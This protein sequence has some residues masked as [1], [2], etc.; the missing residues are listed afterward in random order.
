LFLAVKGVA[1]S[2]AP[3]EDQQILFVS[4][5]YIIRAM[6]EVLAV[7]QAV[8]MGVQRGSPR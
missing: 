6:Q 4:G 1:E 5:P 3:E 7:A 2:H 8:E